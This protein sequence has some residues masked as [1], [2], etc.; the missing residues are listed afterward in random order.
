MGI[1]KSERREY[2]NNL[3]GIVVLMG[4]MVGLYAGWIWAGML[5]SLFAGCV[6]FV[7]ASRLVSRER[8]SR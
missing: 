1:P 6:G 4:T 5:G 8:M 7:I 2:F 3:S